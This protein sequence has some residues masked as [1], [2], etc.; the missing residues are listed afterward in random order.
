M[1]ATTRVAPT[2]LSRRATARPNGRVRVAPTT[3]PATAGSHRRG[4]ACPVPKST[5]M[6]RDP[7]HAARGESGRPRALA[8]AL[9]SPLRW[10]SG[11]PRAVGAGL[12]PARVRPRAP[13][14]H[15][16]R[17][18]T[19]ASPTG[20]PRHEAV[21]RACLGRPYAAS[22]DLVRQGSHT[23]RW[24][25]PRWISRHLEA[26]SGVTNVIASPLRPMRPVRPTRWVNSCSESGR[27]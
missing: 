10:P 25:K 24:L 4:R 5:P 6:R 12:V 23:T 9:G 1:R 27:S 18:A 26:S 2:W 16:A 15:R 21:R 8:G 3:V 22:L 13:S 17:D 20:S 7:S 11:R 14:V 19:R